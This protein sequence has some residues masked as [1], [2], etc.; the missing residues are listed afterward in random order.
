MTDQRPIIGE[1]KTTLQGLIT[2][3]LSMQSTHR[4]LLNITTRVPN[5]PTGCQERTQVPKHYILFC[6]NVFILRILDV[7]AMLRWGRHP[8]NIFSKF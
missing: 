8:R 6:E 1:K 4:V 5:D 3:T 7:Q 2:I